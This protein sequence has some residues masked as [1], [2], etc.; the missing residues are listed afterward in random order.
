MSTSS[1][2]SRSDLISLSD[3]HLRFSEAIRTYHKRTKNDLLFHPLASLFQSCNDS[4]VALSLLQRHAQVSRPLAPRISDEQLKSLLSPTL[5]G[6]YNISLNG[7]EGVGLVIVDVYSFRT[8]ISLNGVIFSGII[9]GES[10]LSC[11]WCPPFGDGLPLFPVRGHSHTKLFQDAQA[12][13]HRDGSQDRLMDIFTRMGRSF[14]QL[15][16]DT[17]LNAKKKFMLDVLSILTSATVEV[18]QGKASEL[19]P[20]S[21]ILFCSPLFR[22][23]CQAAIRQE[24]S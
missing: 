23:D 12:S 18:K 16:P 13:R 24:R 22:K 15:P 10:Y 8:F 11:H 9:T 20:G 1:T 14:D 4:T 5:S 19:I 3:F 6:L 17:S 21:D 2:R 7:D